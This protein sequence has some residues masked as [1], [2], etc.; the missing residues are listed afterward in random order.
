MKV[1]LK[2]T[3]RSFLFAFIIGLTTA[4]GEGFKNIH[5]LDGLIATVVGSLALGGIFY[6]IEV[7]WIPYRKT[8]L[9]KK[10]ARICS[11]NTISETVTHFKFGML[12]V[13]THLEYN[14]KLATYQ[15]SIEL[16]TF[17]IPRNQI[18][19]VVSG[20]KKSFRESECNG[21]LTYAV[22]QTNSWGLKL[23]QKRLDKILN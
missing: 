9:T 13:Y 2:W 15:T 17:H 18:G 8:K 1:L 5:L 12:D 19:F 10:I 14:L 11:S 3:L 23:A 16:V 20:K 21:I 6:F 7:K 22:Y 4:I